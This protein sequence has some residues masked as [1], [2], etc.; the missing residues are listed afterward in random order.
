MSN[1][2]RV[3]IT[4]LG[5]GTSTGVPVIGCDC[6]VCTS[7]DKRDRRLRT[8]AAITVH[9]K[10]FVIDTGPD[11]RQ[12]MLAAKI[13]YIDA[14]LLTH[15]HRDHIAG[16]DDIRAF[17]YVHNKV[18]DFYGSQF[19]IEEV[20][21]CFPYLGGQRFFGSPQVELRLFQNEP[22]EIQGIPIIPIRA[23]HDKMEV[24][25]FRIFDLTYI[26]DANMI[27][28]CELEKIEGSRLIVLN[29]L[30]KSRH[31]SH[32][33]LQEAVDIIERFKPEQAYLTH[34]SHF[35]GLHQEVDSIIPPYIKMAWDGL[36]AF[37]D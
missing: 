19:T 12:Q 17:N 25:G 6:P 16:L 28:E 8:A 18:I 9:D 27:E 7:E 13:Q 2:P 10:T 4:F 29:A 24:F 20:K 37:I 35:I 1:K 3:S 5:T 15:S 14:V 30:R 34:T 26:T 11:F 31:V 23:M 32:F 36:T 21:S 22:F 33:S